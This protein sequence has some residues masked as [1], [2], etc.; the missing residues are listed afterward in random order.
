MWHCVLIVDL[1]HFALGSLLGGKQGDVSGCSA[2]KERFYAVLQLR[3]LRSTRL[4]LSRRLA[5]KVVL[6]VGAV[7]WRG[8]WYAA[9]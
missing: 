8:W 2:V 9:C 4:A 3:V 6:L 5:W 7:V 1:Q